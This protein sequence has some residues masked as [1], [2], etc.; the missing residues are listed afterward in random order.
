M[1]RL[2][3]FRAMLMCFLTVAVANSARAEDAAGDQDRVMLQEVLVTAGKRGE[4]SLLATPMS[5]QAIT[6]E[7]LQSQG[8]QEFADYAR[9][10]SGLT[11]EDQGPGDKKIVIRGL[12]SVGAATTGVYFD[13]IVATANNPQDGGGRQPDFHLI[14]MERIEVLK[15]PQGTLYGASSMSGTVRMLTNKPDASQVSGAFNAGTGSTQGAAGADYDYDGMLNVPVVQDKLA[16]RVVGYQSERRGYIDNDLLGMRD[17]NNEKVAGGRAALRWNID[18]TATLDLMYVHQTTNARGPAWYQP[19]YGR[20]AQADT[21][22]QPWSESMDA[23]N[24]A[25]NWKVAAGTVTASVSKVKRKIDYVYSGARILCTLYGYPQSTCFAFD[26]S[27]VDSFRSSDLQPQDRQILSSELRYASAWQGPFQVVGGLFYDRE[28]NDFSSIVYGQDSQFRILPDLPN[29]YVARDVSNQVTQKAVF[30]ELTYDIT[31]ALSITGGFRAFRF[32]IGQHSQNLATNYQPDDAP[33][34]VTDSTE[35]SATYKGSIQYQFTPGPLLYF[36]YSEGFRSGGNN[37]PDF[38][39]GTVLPPYGSDSLKSYELGTKERLLGGALEL[40]AA[41]YDMEWQ[42]LQQR[43]TAELP[44]NVAIKLM[45]NVGSARIRGSELGVRSIPVRGIDLS[46]G[47]NATYLR[48]TITTAVAGINNVGDR[49]PNVPQFTTNVFAEYALPLLGWRSAARVDYQ[50]VGTNY[51]DFNATRPIYGRQGDYSLV[52][53][54]LS[55]E[56]DSYR[57]AAYVDNAFNSIGVITST[58][59]TRTPVQVYSTRPRSVGI[60]LGYRF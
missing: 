53:F 18:E 48:D 34:V 25:L 1:K 44:D 47:A 46:L 15:G 42:N 36:T 31:H 59:D 9:T 14:D 49:V 2:D 37:E 11:F 51:S 33:V 28:T 60:S 13:D 8:I 5:I 54:R 21:S 39:T 30:G 40:N 57:L 56:R 17:V 27:V 4:Q 12:D 50:Y 38:N 3:V 10:I 16:I 20:F 52:N 23:Y 55:F 43:I 7:Q 19:L 22:P 58:T 24:L 29:I 41:V 35:K 45:A 32:D 26:N 6:S